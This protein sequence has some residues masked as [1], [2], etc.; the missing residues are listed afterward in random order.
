MNFVLKINKR[1]ALSTLPPKHMYVAWQK[2]ILAL[3]AGRAR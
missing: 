2:P 1:T 3:K